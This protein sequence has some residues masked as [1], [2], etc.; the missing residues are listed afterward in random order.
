MLSNI[1]IPTEVWDLVISF[2]PRSSRNSFGALAGTCKRMYLIVRPILFQTQILINCQA[3]ERFCDVF[4]KGL[5]W[6]WTLPQ[7]SLRILSYPGQLVQRLHIYHSLLCPSKHRTGRGNSFIPQVIK[8]LKSPTGF[9]RI[10]WLECLGISE[11]NLMLAVAA[12]PNLKSL[13]L[14]QWTGGI[15]A[16]I[17]CTQIQ[18]LHITFDHFPS[19]M[20]LTP[21]KAPYLEHL[22]VHCSLQYGYTE[23]FFTLGDLPKLLSIK[24]NGMVISI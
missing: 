4:F 1:Y 16:L 22:N 5:C 19:Q 23:G 9:T 14:D 2:I 8:I 17:N 12:S 7:D 10:V 6:R 13:Y 3:T 24:M 20:T 18:S 15:V 21:L 11:S